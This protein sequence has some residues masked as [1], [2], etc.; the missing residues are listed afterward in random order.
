MTKL[1]TAK[2]MY[3]HFGKNIPEISALLGLSEALLKDVA[4]EENWPLPVAI[5]TGSIANV[6]ESPDELKEV[7]ESLN[8]ANRL[9]MQAFESSLLPHY[10]TLKISILEKAQE[11]TEQDTPLTA[12]ELGKLANVYNNLISSTPYIDA[13]TAKAAESGEGRVLKVLIQQ[14][15]ESKEQKV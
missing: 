9:G 14:N 3:T 15:F 2:T 8:S 1:Q 10:M 5:A 12:L 6:P 7:S 4:N 11:L 13:D